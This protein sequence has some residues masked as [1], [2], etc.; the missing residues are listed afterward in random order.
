M[1]HVIINNKTKKVVNIIVWDGQEWLPPIDHIVVRND[2][3]NMGDTW[4]EENNTFIPS[5]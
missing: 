2:V 4:N 1:R 3:G 5:K